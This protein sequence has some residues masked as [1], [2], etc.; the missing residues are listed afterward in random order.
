MADAATSTEPVRHFAPAKLN[1]FLHVIERRADGLHDVRSLIVFCDVGD[2]VAIS[3]ADD[4]MLE[5]D[6]PFAGSL[7]PD[8]IVMRAAQSLRTERAQRGGALVRLTKNLPVGAGL[9]GGSSDAAATLRV[10]TRLWGVENQQ[11]VDRIAAKL[12][13]DVPACLAAR[14][15]LVGGIGDRIELAADLP[16]L[17]LALI[18]PGM[19]VST[20]DVYAG[21]RPGGEVSS[22]D[23]DPPAQLEDLILW[24]GERSNHLTP[25]ALEIVPSIGEVLAFLSAQPACRLA[26]MSGSGATCFG[27]FE[28]RDGAAAAVELAR[29]E[30]PHWWVKAANSLR[31]PP[32]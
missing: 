31:N 1:L 23:A 5:V 8:N 19:S 32:V 6:G 24:L 3:L 2:E 22:A 21:C 30:N 28:D 27:L 12:G 9:G 13:A 20:A 11:S 17:A 25:S 18:N 7:G 14:P 4:L 26:R 10:L 29:R 15:V 16:E